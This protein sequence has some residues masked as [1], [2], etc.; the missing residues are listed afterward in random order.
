MSHHICNAHRSSWQQASACEFT[1]AATF[2]QATGKGT[3][4]RSGRVG[5]EQSKKVRL[6]SEAWLRAGILASRRK[7]KRVIDLAAYRTALC[8]E[9]VQAM[10]QWELV[11]ESVT[12]WRGATHSN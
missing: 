4:H 3:A 5:R 10:P 1:W 7:G 2:T 6:S 9:D 12:F 8:K 11:V